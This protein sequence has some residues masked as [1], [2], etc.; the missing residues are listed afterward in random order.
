MTDE[1]SNKKYWEA[2]IQRFNDKDNG[3][4]I[5][6]RGVPY[7]GQFKKLRAA[8]QSGPDSTPHLVEISSRKDTMLAAEPL[9]IDDMYE[10]SE[11]QKKVTSG[12]QKLVESWGQQRTGEEGAV[13]TWPL[14][15]RPYINAYKK[16]WLSAAGLSV[17]DVNVDAGSLSWDDMFQNVYEP[18]NNTDLAASSDAAPDTTGMKEGDEEILSHYMGQKGIT[19][20]GTLNNAATH[21]ILDTQEARDV[22]KMQKE[23]ID[24][25]YFHSNSINH[26]DEEATT[27]L[28]SNKLGSIHIQ[29]VSDLWASFRQQLG[30]DT[31]EKNYTWGL[32]NTMGTKS[33]YALVPIIVPFKKAFTSQAERDAMKEFITWLAVSEQ[34]PVRRVKQNGWVPAAPDVLNADWFSST[35]LHEKFWST[36]QKTVQD[37]RITELSAVRGGSKINFQ[38][39][40]TMHQRIMQ[41]GMSVEKAT[42]LAAEE[43]N[44]ILKDNGRYEPR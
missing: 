9:R 29:D 43:Q 36:I 40:R 25:G 42:K 8:A 19:T 33:T 26:G 35:S 44:Q 13:V 2:A 37:Y 5:N 24:K 31:Y 22:I 1:P 3:I 7:E 15:V 4:Q 16:D 38:I 39:P 17:E 18:M 32:P 12:V 10:G 21:S 34:E 14:G 28:W 30:A 41:Q 27:L 20:M 6:L 23:G 11:I